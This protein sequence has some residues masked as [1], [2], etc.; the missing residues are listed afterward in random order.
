[1]TTF[2]IPDRLG[3]SLSAEVTTLDAK[4]SSQLLQGT[5]LPC[6]F[7]SLRR[8]R[9]I[10]RAPP[11][12]TTLSAH[13]SVHFSYSCKRWGTGIRRS[14]TTPPR[15]TPM[16]TRRRWRTSRRSTRGPSTACAWW[17]KSGCCQEG[18]TRQASPHHCPTYYFKI[19]GD[20][21]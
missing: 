21:L 16:Q 6:A 1:M 5:S 18:R 13:G 14:S 20:M 10:I 11:I 12:H 9:I 2:S 7:A 19:P 15:A 4:L 8:L 17:T 3:N